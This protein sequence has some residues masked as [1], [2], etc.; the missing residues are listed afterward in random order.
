MLLCAIDPVQQSCATAVTC[1]PVQ[2]V[3][4]VKKQAAVT[5]LLDTAVWYYDPES[6]RNLWGN[7]SA[8][9]PTASISLQAHDNATP[10]DAAWLLHRDTTAVCRRA[11]KPEF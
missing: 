9:V 2:Q 10:R 7:R 6:G 1:V 4:D 3:I 11:A 5:D 8:L